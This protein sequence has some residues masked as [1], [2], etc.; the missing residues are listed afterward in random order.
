MHGEQIRD[1]F[2]NNHTLA[3]EC[4]VDPKFFKYINYGLT[5]VDVAAPLIKKAFV[6]AK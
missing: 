5:G 6:W 3:V 2:P 4:G 1:A